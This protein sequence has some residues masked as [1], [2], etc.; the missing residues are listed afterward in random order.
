MSDDSLAEKGLKGEKAQPKLK[1]FES[2]LAHERKGSPAPSPAQRSFVDI[3]GPMG[4]AVLEVSSKARQGSRPNIFDHRRK[5][6]VVEDAH[7]ER[8]DEEQMRSTPEFKRYEETTNIELFYDLFFI[9]NLTTF[10]ST[11]ETNEVPA[12]KSYA[13]FFF[14]LWFLWVQVGLF[15]V[16]FVQ[17]SIL[18]RVGKAA[19]SGVMVGLAIVGTD[20]NL[21]NEDQTVFKSIAMVLMVSRIVLAF[22]YLSVLREVWNYESTK[23]PLILVVSVYFGAA[24]IYMGTFL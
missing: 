5:H 22:Q 4:L 6:S 19:Q 7:Q 3:S 1:L 2:R 14:I 12:L 8:L 16:R 21:T 9:A 15:D 18:E 10:T 20:F 24:L 23:I 17:D 13:A 11:H